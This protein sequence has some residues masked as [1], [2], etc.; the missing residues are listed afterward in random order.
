MPTNNPRSEDGTWTTWLILA[1]RGFGKGLSLDTKIMT[2]EGLKTMA[3]L[4]DSDQVYTPKGNLTKI[5]A[6]KP[7]MPKKMY[8]L[9]FST[10]EFV[11]CDGD[12][13]WFTQKGKE[14]S[15]KTGKVRD[16]N[17][18]QAT[19]L[20]NKGEGVPQHYIPLAEGYPG[21][22]IE[23]PINPYLLGAWLGDGTNRQGYLCI[24]EQEMLDNCKERGI[25]LL[26][27]VS[28]PD[29]YRIEG[30]TAILNKQDLLHNKHVPE[31]Y[32]QAST[33]QRFELLRGLMDTDGSC[34]KD[35]LYCA[36]G[37]TCKSL[38]DDVARLVASLGLKPRT[39]YKLARL[40]RS[41]KEDYT[42]DTWEVGFTA[43]LPLKIF[44]LSRKQARLNAPGT[45][46]G[47]HKA[48][49][50]TSCESIEPKMVRCLTVE[51][52]GALYCATEFL[53]PTHN[54]RT[55][56]QSV[57]EVVNAGLAGRIALVAPTAADCRDVIVEGESGILANASPLN[58]PNYEP[59][60]RRITWANGAIATTYSAEEP[61]ALRGPQ[62]DFAWCD[63]LCRWKYPQ[64]TWDMLQ[65]G[66]RLGT[67]PRQ[68]IT[69]TPKPIKTLKDIMADPMTITT[70]GNTLDNRD[71]LARSFMASIVKKYEGTRLGRQE[72]A[73]EILDD[74]P[75]ALWS[76]EMMDNAFYK[77]AVPELVRVV[78]AID[79]SGSSG[80]DDKADEIGIVVAGKGV[81]GRA[82]VLEDGSC[83]LSPAGWGK[84]AVGLFHKHKADHIVA[85]INYGG[86]MVEHVL[87]SIDQTIPFKKVTASRGKVLRAEPVAA[88][89]E[90]NR[91]SHVGHFAE[92]EEQ[93]CLLAQ[94][95]YLGVGSPDR[96]DA[97]VWAISDLALGNLM[98]GQ[99]LHDLMRRQ[100]RENTERSAVVTK[101]QPQYAV[102]SVEWQQLNGQKN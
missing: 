66:L 97:L 89:Y 39:T 64:D 81:D 77:G 16:T 21:Q 46:A 17:E 38:I 33:E 98:A 27:G 19:L 50:I 63:E 80:D 1:G 96:L 57:L 71:N 14:R 29:L 11:E 5:I 62:H 99:A 25:E 69:T 55:G 35:G 12:H 76:R 74:V 56:G 59:S 101:D 61:E 40:K 86:A 85:E 54:T 31:V 47:R 70:R 32:F 83:S 18:V 22:E 84:K 75:G 6:H 51:D 37:N 10:G 100:N 93:M 7:Y 58:K 67:H 90:Q 26:K 43:Y 15:F 42:C 45:Q 3:D 4:T 9:G 92:L 95:G 34:Q 49:T 52:S 72:L 78:V 88:L 24:F 8:R 73:A 23:L 41:G 13:L 44:G 20:S 53:I 36:F 79:P 30:L 68:V 48:R 2:A 87:R 65:F 60:K 91:V 94:D 28:N 102:G 82:Y